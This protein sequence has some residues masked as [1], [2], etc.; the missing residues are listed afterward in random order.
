MRLLYILMTNNVN[1]NVTRLEQQQT[2]YCN[3]SQHS[4]YG[5]NH[6]HDHDHNH[7]NNRENTATITN[8]I[9]IN[10][11]ITYTKNNSFNPVF[12]WSRIKGDNRNIQKKINYVAFDL[13]TKAVDDE[14][15][16]ASF[17]NLKKDGIDV[18]VSNILNQLD[19]VSD[20]KKTIKK[21]LDDKYKE[22][23]SK[24]KAKT[25]KDGPKT[26]E[27]ISSIQN[28]IDNSLGDNESKKLFIIDK[29]RDMK[30]A[31]NDITGT[32]PT[33]IFLL[34][35]NLFTRPVV[36]FYFLRTK[37]LVKNLLI[38]SDQA[39]SDLSNAVSDDEKKTAQ[40]SLNYYIKE[41]G[42]MLT[43][44]NK[45]Q[46]HTMN[47]FWRSSDGSKTG[48]FGSDL[49]EASLVMEKSS[50]IMKY[51]LETSIKQK[52]FCDEFKRFLA[53]QNGQKPI[54]KGKINLDTSNNDKIACIK[55][56]ETPD[57]ADATKKIITF[58]ISQID[59]KDSENLAK[60]DNTIYLPTAMTKLLID[61]N[62]ESEDE[63]K[64]VDNFELVSNNIETV[65]VAWIDMDA[66]NAGEYIDK[67]DI[68]VF[69]DN[70]NR[71]YKNIEDSANNQDDLSE[72]KTADREITDFI[73]KLSDIKTQHHNA[74]KHAEDKIKDSYK[75]V[76]GYLINIAKSITEKKDDQYELISDIDKKNT[77]YQTYNDIINRAIGDIYQQKY[78]D[79][80]EFMNDPN[81]NNITKEI[82]KKIQ[83]SKMNNTTIN[84]HIDGFIKKAKR[85]QSELRDNIRNKNEQIQEERKETRL[86]IQQSHLKSHGGHGHGHCGHSHD[87]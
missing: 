6:N 83:N 31:M 48:G 54:I 29:L 72:M 15:A 10:P 18:G 70:I 42:V 21:I 25:T 65:R 45:E 51:E 22:I 41:A 1:N 2:Q 79:I 28:N 36:L 59:K 50:E 49:R 86:L 8:Q 56:I 87:H 63:N 68:S 26:M 62:K 55:I 58:D 37:T 12:D 73:S 60:D 44:I 7:N 39:L 9:D 81:K 61:L 5:N 67:E 4:L 57:P 11:I 84:F 16:P 71:I 82:S 64:F 34:I 30:K 19:D 69:N 52:F 38:K 3:H 32:F 74:I 85:L 23:E 75:K 78:K 77:S 35:Y 27:L 66:H 40:N 33:S 76:S 14:G 13:S 46:Y 43:D 47:S 17:D 53:L 80:V 24:E 20:Y